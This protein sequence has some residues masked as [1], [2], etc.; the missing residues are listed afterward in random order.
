MNRA[1]VLDL[2]GFAFTG[3]QA[4]TDLMREVE[5]LSVPAA[6][7]EFILL[8]APG[9]LL[10]LEDALV[11]DW[12]PVR[13]DGAI[14]RFRRLVQRVGR[15]VSATKP[16]TLF[17]TIGWNYDEV[18]RGQFLPLSDAYVRKLIEMEWQ[19]P[20]PFA[21]IDMDASEMGVRHA[22]GHVIGLRA[23]TVPLTLAKPKTFYEDTRA[24]LEALLSSNVAPGTA[25]IVTHNMLEP[26][27]PARGMR[28]FES[29]RS[30]VIDRDPRDNY[31][32]GAPY[33]WFAADIDD[34]IRKF[35]FQR[36]AIDH[37]GDPSVLRMKFEDLVFEPDA[38]AEKLLAHAG[39]PRS[40]WRPRTHFFA[41][42]SRENVGAHARWPRQEEIRRIER[43]L[44]EYC[45]ARV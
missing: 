16:W 25:T 41:E 23:R 19:A 32:T 28:L 20:W 29:I 40:A 2:S 1:R 24:Y 9:G 14:R 12:S 11:R 5:G 18:Y 22:L 31:V 43:E 30:V 35:R 15:R 21:M 38:V 13:S 44:G 3:K 39:A 4:V 27:S 42:R 8:R 7:F 37:T 6:E 34:F 26:Y 10:D 45:D 36:Q 17:Q 33:K